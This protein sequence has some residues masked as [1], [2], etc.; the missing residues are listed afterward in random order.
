[1][2]IAALFCGLVAGLFVLVA[3]AGFGVDLLAAFLRLWPDAAAALGTL[4]WY[5]LSAGAILGG[6]LSLIAPA[7]GALLLL[8][9][10]A[11]WASVGLI[12]TALLRFELLAPAAMSGAGAVLAFLAGELQLRRRRE[13][14]RNRLAALYEEADRSEID[15]EAREAALSMDLLTVTR[16]AAPPRPR[17]EIPLTLDDVAPVEPE[18][19]R[20]SAKAM[21]PDPPTRNSPFDRQHAAPDPAP[22]RSL[23][24]RPAAPVHRHGWQNE[25]RRDGPSPRRTLLVWV[26]AVNGVV[27]VGLM[28]AVGYMLV[29]RTPPASNAVTTTDVAEPADPPAAEAAPA[30]RLTPNLLPELAPPGA[31]PQDH[32]VLPMAP[33]SDVVADTSLPAAADGGFSDPHA[34]CG[35]VRTIDYVDARYTGPRF[36]P[37]IAEALRVPPQSAADRISWRCVDGVVYACTS[38][39][40]PACAMTPTAQEMLDYCQRNP[41]AA[42]LLAPNG[43]WSCDGVRP[44]IPDGAS[45]PVDARG[46]FPSAWIPVPRPPSD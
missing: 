32:L 39:D 45:W 22:R 5:A 42:R 36:T 1:M 7:P 3:P 41:G 30:A 46:F 29:V 40:W 28:L 10:G 16:E 23:F 25:A 8:A 33:T 18:R 15:A 43:T 11:G 14:R 13:A 44:R 17:H 21:W 20:H 9:A 26:A 24:D 31:E 12:D 2:R 37:D 6:L 35:A 4:A 34:Y 27:L 38:F 19:P